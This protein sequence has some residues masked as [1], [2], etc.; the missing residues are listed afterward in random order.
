MGKEL[1]DLK[2]KYFNRKRREYIANTT[3]TAEAAAKAAKGKG[4]N[5][6]SNGGVDDQPRV[7]TEAINML[8]GEMCVK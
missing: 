1:N 5:N 7:S 6:N 2:T 3:T 4:T 8:T